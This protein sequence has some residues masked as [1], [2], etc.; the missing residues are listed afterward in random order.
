MQRTAATTDRS[1]SFG[2]VQQVPV[3]R[4]SMAIER[5][6]CLFGTGMKHDTG[7]LVMSTEVYTRDLDARD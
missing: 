7:D 4:R 6:R 5:P 3:K 2:N 1:Y